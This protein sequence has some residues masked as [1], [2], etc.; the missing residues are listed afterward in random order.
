[1]AI[2]L[3]AV[4]VIVTT[5]AGEIQVS[6]R[7]K[8][9]VSAGFL[10][11]FLVPSSCFSPSLP[12]PKRKPRNPVNLGRAE[13]DYSDNSCSTCGRYDGELLV[14]AESL[15]RRLLPAFE[16]PTGVC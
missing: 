12:P 4:A 15:G 7:F 8:A 10:I 3:S 13:G 11:P 9:S 6:P 1:M 5:M 2:A 16:T 14:L